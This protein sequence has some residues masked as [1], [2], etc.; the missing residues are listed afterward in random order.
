MKYHF[1]IHKGGKGY[2]AQCVEL[3]GCRTQGKTLE[4]LRANMKVA[5]NLYLDE[6]EDSA[7][8]FPMPKQVRRSKRVEEVVVDP[9]VAFAFLLRRERLLNHMTQQSVAAR[10]NVGLYSYQRLE[11]AKTA[12]P[13]LAT[14]AK[15]SKVFLRFPFA[16]IVKW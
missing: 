15:V 14:V 5:L 13:R 8:I 12:N 1:R 6:P 9:Q 7:T 2:W 11:S 3:D 16:Q 10:M 4:K